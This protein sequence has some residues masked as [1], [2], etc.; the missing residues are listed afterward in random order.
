[1]N[2]KAWSR[3]Y[4]VVSY[5]TPGGEPKLRLTRVHKKSGKTKTVVAQTNVFDAI[6]EAHDGHVGRDITYGKL[7]DKFYN[8]TQDIVQTFINYCPV[9]DQ[10]NIKVKPLKGAVK[11][12]KSY[13]FRERFQVDLID[14]RVVQKKNIY[15]VTMRWIITLKDHFTG[16]VYLV[17]IPRKRPKYV[18][19]ELDKIFAVIGYPSIF[20]TDNGNEFTA[21]EILQVLKEINPS[22]ITVTGRPRRPSDQGSVENMNKFVKRI[23]QIDP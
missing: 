4:K 20:H 21:K 11:P 16:F 5:T 18:A 7:A 19:Y 12:I 15:G 6:A 10:K 13:N 14:M 22:I 3:K 2:G 1:M 23:L 9:C 8:I 17:A